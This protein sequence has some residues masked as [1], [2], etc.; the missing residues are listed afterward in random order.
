MPV[1]G[2][3]RAA[4]RHVQP[5]SPGE[6]RQGAEEDREPLPPEEPSREQDRRGV[7]RFV[8][9]RRKVVE[10]E[11]VQDRRGGPQTRLVGAHHFVPDSVGHEQGVADAL[12]IV[13]FRREQR[14]ED[15]QC[16]LLRFVQRA[17]PT[18]GLLDAAGLAQDG[19]VRRHD[20]RAIDPRGQKVR[21]LRMVNDE[22]IR[23]VLA[24]QI[25]EPTSEGE[26]EFQIV[27]HHASTVRHWDR[28][29]V[30]DR[31]PRLL[32]SEDRHFVAGAEA[33]EQ[34]A[35]VG[36]NPAPDATVFRSRYRDLRGLRSP[37]FFE[38]RDPRRTS[39]ARTQW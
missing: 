38:S 37:D 20:D 6:F 1:P 31:R 13:D 11:S 14:R 28:R 17:A 24:D 25:R 32:P 35:H 33:V 19:R 23:P 22:K 8:A 4:A 7:R 3:D 26:L 18:P 29:D 15:G 39:S 34:L 27:R 30:R 36:P 12:P 5:L 16:R 21:H 10:G 9:D 2:L